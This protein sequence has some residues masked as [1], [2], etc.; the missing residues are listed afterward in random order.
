MPAPRGTHSSDRPR[1]GPRPRGEPSSRTEGQLNAPSCHRS[2]PASNSATTSTVRPTRPDRRCTRVHEVGDELE[3][4]THAGVTR[5]GQRREPGRHTRRRARRLRGGPVVARRRS[6]PGRREP[7][8][9][10]A[11]ARPPRSAYR[12]RTSRRPSA[13]PG[14]RRSHLPRLPRRRALRARRARAEPRAPR[15]RSRSSSAPM[16]PRRRELRRAQTSRLRARGRARA[17]GT[18]RPRNRPLHASA[19]PRRQ[20]LRHRSRRDSPLACPRRRQTLRAQGGRPSEITRHATVYVPSARRFG[21]VASTMSPDGRW[22]S[23]PSTR[24]ACPS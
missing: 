16:T 13:R 12:A 17:T 8:R 4:A 6:R 11:R 9:T 1:A 20:A 21:I 7:R 3:A 18:A 5:D 23:P 19:S 15:R 10:L 2:A 24:R 22:S 14:K